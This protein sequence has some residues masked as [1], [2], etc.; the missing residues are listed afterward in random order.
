MGSE[1]VLYVLLKDGAIGAY[2]PAAVD[3][4][5][6]RVGDPEGL[7]LADAGLDGGR[8]LSAGHAGANLLRVEPHLGGVVEHS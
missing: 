3:E 6:R 2:Q 5:G 8:G 1:L 4:D 7:S